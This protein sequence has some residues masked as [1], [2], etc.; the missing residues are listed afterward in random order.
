MPPM[1]CRIRARASRCPPEWALDDLGHVRQ[2]PELVRARKYLAD[3]G[4]LGASYQLKP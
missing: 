1:L 2:V 3:A 4:P